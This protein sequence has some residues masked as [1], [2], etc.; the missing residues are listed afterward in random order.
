MLVGTLFTLFVP[1]TFYMVVG[2]RKKARDLAIAPTA[3]IGDVGS[4]SKGV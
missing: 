3:S 4:V 2:G 1:P